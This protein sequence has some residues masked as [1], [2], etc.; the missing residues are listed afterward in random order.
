ML[1]V[2]SLQHVRNTVLISVKRLDLSASVI[3]PIAGH[4]FPENFHDGWV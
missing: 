4:A 2:D 3:A 1:V